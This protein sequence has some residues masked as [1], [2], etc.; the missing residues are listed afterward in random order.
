MT[1]VP[2]DSPPLVKFTLMPIPAI[3]YFKPFI[4][5]TAFQQNATNLL[6]FN[7]KIIRPFNADVDLAY[8]LDR[9]D[10]AQQH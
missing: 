3:T 10:K 8:F 5:P 1:V 4:F 9:S 6:P 2:P 7:Q